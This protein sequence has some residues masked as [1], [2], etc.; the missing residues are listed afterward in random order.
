[1]LYFIRNSVSLRNLVRLASLLEVPVYLSKAQETVQAFR[2]SLS[3]FPFALPAL[4]ASF[5]L[6]SNGLK[7]VL[8][9]VII[10]NSYI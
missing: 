7:E 1:V 2:L 4:V 5:M 3:K 6:V 10:Y 9:I 8:I